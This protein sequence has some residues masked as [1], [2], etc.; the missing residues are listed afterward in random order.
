MNVQ[1]RD[2]LTGVS[3]MAYFSDPP[4]GVECYLQLDGK[5]YALSIQNYTPAYAPSTPPPVYLGGVEQCLQRLAVSM[6]QMAAHAALSK[7][8]E[9]E[10]DYW[11]IRC[12]AYEQELNVALDKLR[13]LE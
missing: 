13:K 8:I 1:V 2:L 9:G 7:G 6:E 11:K 10:L 5:T 12:A 4:S 3:S